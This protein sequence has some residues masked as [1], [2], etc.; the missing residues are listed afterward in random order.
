[1]LSSTVLEVAIGLVFCFASVALITSSVYEAIASQLNFRSKTLLIGIQK[2]LNAEKSADQELILGIYNHALASPL[3]DGLAKKIE[4]LKNKPSYIDSAHFASALI[5]TLQTHSGDFAMLSSD[6]DGIKNEQLRQL[7]RSMY[8]SSAGKVENLQTALATWFDAGMQRVSGAYK[9]QSQRWCFIIALVLAVIF[10]I[11]SFHLFS[12]LWQHPALITEISTPQS[13]SDA[14]KALHTLPIGWQTNTELWASNVD[15]LIKMTGWIVTAS[16]SLFGG[17]FWFDLLKNLIN[18]R[19]TGTK[20]KEAVNSPP[21]R[22][23]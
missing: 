11:D 1:M 8:D 23:V 16:A 21:A 10:N 18:L 14:L 19:G 5:D 22:K 12:V 6:I 17:P 9:R 13:S 4:D 20:P 2:L 7:L 15:F 3:G